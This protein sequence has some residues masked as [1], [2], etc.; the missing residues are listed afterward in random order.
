MA[1]SAEVHTTQVGLR[2]RKFLF[3]VA[4]EIWFLLVQIANNLDIQIFNVQ[5]GQV[6]VAV[7]SDFPAHDQGNFTTSPAPHGEFFAA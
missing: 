5:R 3:V 4:L 1:Y 6:N 2:S 7:K